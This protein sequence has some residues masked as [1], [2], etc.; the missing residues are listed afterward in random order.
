[1]RSV[2]LRE[3]KWFTKGHR[4]GKWYRDV[5]RSETDSAQAPYLHTGPLTLETLLSHRNI[6]QVMC[7][8]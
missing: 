7:A 3:V 8:I 6:T 4:A 1:M 2:T 5:T